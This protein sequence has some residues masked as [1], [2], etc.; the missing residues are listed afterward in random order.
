MCRPSQTP[1]LNV[2]R[3][4]RPAEASLGSKKRG[5]AP[6]PIHGISKI[7]LK[8]VV[9]HFRLSAPTYPTPLKS[10]H[11]VGLESSSTGSS[12]PADS[13]KPVPLAVV[14]LDSRQGQ[15]ESQH[16]AEITLREHP[17]GPSQ[18]FVL[19]KQS[20]TVGS[21]P[22]VRTS[23][24]STVR[25]PGKTAETIVPIC[26]PPAR[27]DPLSPRKQL[28]QST[29]SRRVRDWDPRAQPLRANPFPEVTD[30]FCRLPTS[31]A[32]IVP[33]TRGCSPWR[34]ETCGAVMST[35]GR[36]W[37]SVD[38]T[39]SSGF[40]RAAGGAPDTTRRA[41]CTDGRSARARAPGFAATAAPSYS[42]GPGTCPDGRVSAQLGTV[43]R[44]P[45][46]P[47]SPV[48]LTK[49]GPL[50]ALDSLTRLNEAAA[51]SYLF[52]S[53]APIPKSDERFARQ[54]RCGPP[55]E[56]PLASPRSGIV[57]H[58][59]GPDRYA[60]T[61][62]LLRR[63]RS[64]G[65]ATLKGIPPI[66]FAY[67]LRVYWPV[68]SH[69][70]QTPWSVFQD[71]PNGEPAGRRQEHADAE[72]RQEAR[73]AHH[74]RDDDVST[75]M[76]TARA[77]AAVA[78]RVGP[79]PE[80]IGGPARHRSTSD[81]G[82]SPAPIR[83]PPDNF[84]ALFSLFIFPSSCLLSLSPIFSLGR[85]LPPDWGC[86]P[87]QPD[88]PTAPRGATG[89][90]H[91]GALTLS[92][93]PFQ[94]T[95]ARSART[96]LQTTI[97]T[98]RDV[99]SQRALPGSLAVT[100]GILVFF[101]LRLLICSLPTGGQ[102][103]PPNE[104]PRPLR[105]GGV[106][107][108]TL[109]SAE[110]RQLAFKD[111]MIHGILSYRISPFFT[112]QAEIRCR[113]S[114]WTR[115]RRRHA[116]RVRRPATLRLVSVPWHIPRRGSVYGRGC[117]GRFEWFVAF[118]PFGDE[119][120]R[121][122]APCGYHAFSGRS[123]EEDPSAGSPTETLLRLLLPLNDKVQWTS[124]DVAGS[125]PP[126]SPRSEHFT[127]PFNRQITPPTKNGHAP[128]PIESRKSSQSV[129][130]YYV[131]T[132]TGG[133]TRPVKAR[134]ASPVEGTSRPVHT[135]GGPLCPTQDLPSNGS[136]LRDLD[137][138]H[139]NYQTRPGKTNLSHDGLN[140]AHVPYW[141]V[142]NPTLGEFC[143]ITMI[144]RADIEGSK[145][146]VAMNAWLPQASYPCG[147]FSDTSSFKF[148]RSKG[149]I[150]H[151]FTVRI[152][153]GNQ[154]QTSFYPF[155]PHEISVLVELILGHLRYLLT[156]VPP[157]PNSPPD[158]VFRPDRPAEASLGSKKRGIAP[159]PIHGISKITL[160]VVVFHFRLSAPTYPTPLK[161]FHKVGL[162][163]SSTGSSFPA[164]SAKP[165][166]LAVVSLDS[167]QGHSESTVRR[168]GEDRRNDRSQSVPP[169]GTR[170]PAL[171]P[172][173][174][175]EQ[176]TD[177]R[178]GSGTGTPRAQPSE[179]ILFPRLRIHFADFPL[180]TLF[181]RPEAVHLGDLMRC[182]YEYDRGVDGTRSS[183]FSRAAGGAPDT[184]RRAICTDG[185]SARARAPGFAATAAP[186]Y[187]SGPGTCPD[188]RVS[189][190]L[191]TVTR[192]PVHPASPVLL[193]KNGPLGA[194]DSLTRLNEA[195]APS[196]LFKSF[197][198]IPK[199]DERFA[200]QYR[201]GPPPEFPLASPRSGI[202]HHL[203]GPDRYALTRT[204]LRRS[205]S[206]GGATL[207]GIPPI[208]FLTPYGPTPGARRCR[209]TPEARAAHHD[210][211]DDVSAGMTTAR[212]WAAVAIRVGPR[213]ESIGG[214][215]RHRSTSDRG[216][217][218]API[219]FPPDNFK[220]SLTLFS[221][222]FSSFPRGTCLLSVSRPYLALDG[223]YRPIG[224]AFPNNPTRR[225]RL[226]VRQGPGTTGLSP[227]P[228]PPSRGLG[229]GP[230]LRT[231]LQTTIRTP[232]DVRFSSWALPGSLAVTKGILA[233]GRPTSAT[234]RDPAP[235]ARRGRLGAT[236]RDTQADVP[237]AEWRRAQ[238][239]FKDSM[240]H[241]ILQFTPNVDAGTHIVSEAAGD[242]LWFQFLGTFRAGV[243]FTD[244]VATV[245]SNGLW[246]DGRH[247]VPPT[248]WGRKAAKPLAPCGYHAFSGRSAGAGFDNDPSA[249]SPTETLLRLLLP[250]NDKVQWTSRDVAGSEPP[251]SPRSEH[252]TGPFNR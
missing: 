57:H 216:A 234:K 100:K 162:E 237:S 195:A 227:S 175:L 176:S 13:A 221:K 43:T 106:W 15:W 251:T 148:R 166:P 215:A 28:E 17:Q 225:Q 180:P 9:F 61:R 5:I 40:S 149:S 165:V 35:T 157:Q 58:L 54:Y 239:A 144:G 209:G 154:N 202:V 143:F 213:P 99:D 158:N 183:G 233:H 90:G 198:P 160:K 104:I 189:A 203:S 110:W 36:G 121:S 128:P 152:R 7:T 4:D 127:G 10:F 244:E 11:K 32:Y 56:F 181:H 124:R 178:R 14:S 78:I 115:R 68:D 155:V 83:F 145:S 130:P 109:P 65:G 132:C 161:S 86:I 247:G 133:T 74:D 47:A 42:S 246:P 169:A 21:P 41:I 119:R 241:G 142:N 34:P 51:P 31:L 177:S 205:R 131:W 12:F 232:R 179:P 19:I 101:F 117:H 6:P 141:W 49:N 59:S 151:A 102:L 114:F 231:L 80:S 238:L 172:R 71:G 116:H 3:P 228:A 171:S 210:R 126:T 85:N 37:H 153:T 108:Q 62:T 194:L 199:S 55:P 96:L 156:D 107:G 52:K 217:S 111:S 229:P 84:K 206:V 70:C 191:G 226:V 79:R 60:L 29:D 48:L 18:C 118:P 24:E 207:K 122:P 72:A 20:E 120:P 98:P 248:V 91:N 163:S 88:S 249:G 93:A 245:A 200:R 212:A 188:G 77:W 50:G 223:I 123:A 92:G 1:H 87:K 184:T 103:P 69:T 214:P 125:E 33:S 112:M 81:R 53:F 182:G 135:R 39:R 129:N 113:E 230:P 196:Y 45:V 208:S 22:L 185:R 190:Q 147:N 95:W 150:G 94:G 219:R 64:V 23:S 26:P 236:V 66:S 235:L 174:Q 218:P 167:R 193:T 146:N 46:H 252:F 8:V 243:R 25:R 105:G 44:L 136:S 173:K 240:I 73:A 222:S 201:C 38:G 138:T 224:A 204:L 27:G 97:R 63:S 192:L 89:S 250:L 186:S 242:A 220:H 67:A 76:T 164:D 30:P 16:W 82:A 134:S 140:P 170:R 139:S 75:G 137:C 197:A 2:F 168:P 159:P 211:D 187:S